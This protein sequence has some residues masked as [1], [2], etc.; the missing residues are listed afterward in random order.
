V[1][2]GAKVPPQQAAEMEEMQRCPT[3]GYVGRETSKSTCHNR[4]QE[5]YLAPKSRRKKGWPVPEAFP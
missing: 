2:A 1:Q 3:Y 4:L 5:R